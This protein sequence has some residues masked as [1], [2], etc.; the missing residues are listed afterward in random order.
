MDI[1]KNQL[2]LKCLKISQ[3]SLKQLAQIHSLQQCFSIGA[4]L[5]CELHLGELPQ[6]MTKTEPKISIV[7]QQLLSDL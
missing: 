6:L 5:R 7:K 2:S 4:I 1:L 3:Y